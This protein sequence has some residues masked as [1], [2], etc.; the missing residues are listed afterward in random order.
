MISH[1]LNQQKIY[2]KRTLLLFALL[3]ASS[4]GALKAQE[5]GFQEFSGEV[6]DVTS[7][8]PLVFATLTLAGTN[9]ST[10]TN[11]EGKFLL[12]VPSNTTSKEVIVAFLGL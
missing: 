12:K 6:K 11:T 5:N 7:K 8:Q 9:V 4:W 1:P 2:L 3:L 10:I